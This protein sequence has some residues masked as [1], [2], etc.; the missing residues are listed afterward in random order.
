LA[1]DYE[2]LLAGEAKPGFATHD[3]ILCFEIAHFL[4]EEG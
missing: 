3:G 2:Q 4:Y 1:S